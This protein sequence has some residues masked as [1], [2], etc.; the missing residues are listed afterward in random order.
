MPEKQSTKPLSN[1]LVTKAIEENGCFSLIYRRDRHLDR[2][3]RRIYFYF[4][5]H[6]AI[7]ARVDK[8]DFI[9]AIRETLGCGKITK[10]ERQ[11][12]LDVFS[13]RDSKS[14]VRILHKHNFQNRN[15][16]SDF[17]LWEEAI[18]LILKNQERKINAEKGKR[19]FLSTWAKF[20]PRDMRRLFRIREEMKTFKRWKK[21]D[22]KWTNSL[23]ARPF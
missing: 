2:G 17:I 10:T 20:E 7:T 12:R 6:L 14:I 11:A 21:A 1:A 16:K 13:P 15:K 4:R 23:M 9:K 5:P 19:G 3:S 18:E 8:L 22:Y